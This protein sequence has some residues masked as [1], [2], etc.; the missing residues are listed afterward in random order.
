MTPSQNLAEEGETLSNETKE[1]AIKKE[2]ARLNNILADVDDKKRKTAEGLIEE[3][4]FMRA[5]LQELKREIDINGP[6]DEM[7]QGDYSILR[8]H[9]ALKS[10]NTVIQRYTNITKQLLDLLP[11]DVQTEDADILEEFVLSRGA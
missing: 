8:E 2:I 3:S 10:Y 11:K 7:S 6:I 4:A 1:K 9:P 5:T